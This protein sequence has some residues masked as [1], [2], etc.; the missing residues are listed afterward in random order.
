M[1]SIDPTIDG[2]VQLGLGTEEEHENLTNDFVILQNFPQKIFE[3]MS[4]TLENEGLFPRCKLYIK[5][6]GSINSS[7][8]ANSKSLTK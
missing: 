6:E 2:A 1:E 5:D 3:D 8:D 4:N 7:G